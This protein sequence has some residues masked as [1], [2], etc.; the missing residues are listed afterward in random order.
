[1]NEEKSMLLFGVVSEVCSPGYGSVRREY[2]TFSV[3]GAEPL[4]ADFRVPNDHGWTVG[5]AVAISVVLV[6]RK[7]ITQ[8]AGAAESRT[9]SS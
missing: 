7:P 2:V 8:T 6:G 9:A 1:V 4:W 5:D 3:A